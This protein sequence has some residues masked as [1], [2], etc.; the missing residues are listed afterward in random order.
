MAILAAVLATAMAGGTQARDSLGVFESWGAFRDPQTPRCFAIAQPARVGTEGRWSPF[1]AIGYWPRANVRG[2]VHIRLSR[3]I[4]ARSTLSLTI[5]ERRFALTGGGADAWA[6]NRQVDAAIVAAM[7]SAT[8][9]SIAAQ[10][11]TGAGFADTYRL[12]GAATAID[13]AA[14]GCGRLR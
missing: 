11:R 3:E 10:A 7:R 1:A 8:S 12:R 14:L 4:A 5:G 9:M 13:A 6:P 2:Q